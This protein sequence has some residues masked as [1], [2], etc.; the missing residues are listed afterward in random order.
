MNSKTVAKLLLLVIIGFGAVQSANAIIEI[1]EAKAIQQFQQMQ[2]EREIRECKEQ[3]F[4]DGQKGVIVF[5]FTRIT[6]WVL[7]NSEC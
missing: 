3:Q 6:R 5:A 2:R 4:S 7:H 1:K